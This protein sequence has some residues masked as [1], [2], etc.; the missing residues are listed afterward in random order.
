MLVGLP[1]V[2]HAVVGKGATNLL[3]VLAEDLGLLVAGAQ[4]GELA[5]VQPLEQL[6]HGVREVPSHLARQVDLLVVLALGARKLGKAR[7]AHGDAVMADAVL[8]HV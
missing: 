2:L 5:V 3:D 8:D 6:A 7:L 1:V 4:V